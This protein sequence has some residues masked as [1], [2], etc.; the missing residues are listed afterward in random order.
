MDCGRFLRSFISTQQTPLTSV[1]NAACLRHHR[2]LSTSDTEVDDAVDDNDDDFTLPVIS[3]HTPSACASQVAKAT[4]ALSNATALASPTHFF[5]RARYRS[6]PVVLSS[7]KQIRDNSEHNYFCYHPVDLLH[8]VLNYADEPIDV[9]PPC[10]DRAHVPSPVEACAT[11]VVGTRFDVLDRTTQAAPPKVLIAIPVCSDMPKPSHV[12]TWPR[13]RNILSKLQNRRSLDVYIPLPCKE[14]T[15]VAP[16]KVRLL[17]KPPMDISLPFDSTD[18]DASAFLKIL[19]AVLESRREECSRPT[20]I[21]Q[22]SPAE[23]SR[24]SRLTCPSGVNTTF[25]NLCRFSSM[26]SLIR[27]SIVIKLAQEKLDLQ[28]CLLYF[29]KEKGR[30][31]DVIT[32]KVMKPLYDRYRAVRRLVRLASNSAVRD[33]RPRAATATV[34]RSKATSAELPTAVATSSV[35]VS[36]QPVLVEVAAGDA[37]TC[38]PISIGEL[39][40]QKTSDASVPSTH[41]D[42]E[43]TAST[44]GH[45]TSS[46]F[47]DWDISLAEFTQTAQEL[48]PSEL[49]T[50]R[51]EVLS[52]KHKLQRVLHDFEK[53][54]QEATNR[55]PSKRDRDE[56]RGEY[57]RYRDFKQRLYIIDRLLEAPQTPLEVLLAAAQS[58]G[59]AHRRRRHDEQPVGL[60]HGSRVPVLH[61]PDSTSCT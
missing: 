52:A 21:E 39:E 49:S 20:E 46:V 5:P 19:Q 54:I 23:V 37:G 13:K 6:P 12:F 30:P 9:V 47:L 38:D 34:S 31:C 56:L 44:T 36:Y 2:A 24:F 41:T 43:Q 7:H 26:L 28:K 18:M 48:T 50:G 59:R 42:T 16:A 57:N 1:V 17:E 45:A 25:A 60:C 58:V 8:E 10:S 4:A 29:E 35:E 3:Q 53:G 32:K 15:L 40:P 33:A 61:S 14:D 27:F 55:P 51:A 22:M 11:V